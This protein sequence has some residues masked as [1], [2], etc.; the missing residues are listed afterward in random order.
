M[1]IIFV[2]G[3]ARSGKSKFAEEMAKR[4]EKRS[5][6]IA[7]AQALDEEMAHRIALHRQRRP[8]EWITIE[9]PLYVSRA[10][11]NINDNKHLAGFGTVLLDCLALL[12]SNWLPLKK[13]E[14]PATWEGLR[15][16]LLS[17]IKAMINEA[18][19]MNKRIIVV[20]NEV[21]LGIVPEYPLG[22]LYR[23]L[24]GQVNQM[25]AAAADEVYFMVSG[26]PLKIK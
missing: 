24:L 7:T 12:V 15:K 20:S 18:E 14:D 17:E 2:T 19:R 3:G 13:A 8:P 21:G 25:V 11:K 1:S 26:I 23:D 4:S 9:E 10:L 16:D 22:R 6:Y 5:I